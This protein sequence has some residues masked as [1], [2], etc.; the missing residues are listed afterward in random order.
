MPTS[1]FQQIII[2]EVLVHTACSTSLSQQP[3]RVMTFYSVMPF[4]SLRNVLILQESFYFPFCGSGLGTV[5][6]VFYCKYYNQKNGCSHNLLCK[7]N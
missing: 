3:F 2:V 1:I 5:H 4:C 7:L 6:S